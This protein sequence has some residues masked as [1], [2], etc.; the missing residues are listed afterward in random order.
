[1][2]GSHPPL[3][4]VK[5]LREGRPKLHIA[6]GQDAAFTLSTLPHLL[7]LYMQPLSLRH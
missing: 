1:M 3:N 5:L 4:G 6:L 7:I 2:T